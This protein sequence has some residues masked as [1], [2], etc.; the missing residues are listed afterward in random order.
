MNYEYFISFVSWIVLI[1]GILLITINATIKKFLFNKKEVHHREWDQYITC[2][3]LRFNLNTI[4]GRVAAAGR[5]E[6]KR[7]LPI[8][9]HSYKREGIINWRLHYVRIIL[10]FSVIFSTLATWVLFKIFP[11]IPDAPAVVTVFTGMFGCICGAVGLYDFL[12]KNDNSKK[13]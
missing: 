6:C 5:A 13:Q 3:G 7:F 12:S 4:E 1:L 11:A 8:W 10:L 9:P 2:G